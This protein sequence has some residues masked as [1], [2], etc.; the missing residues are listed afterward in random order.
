METVDT[1]KRRS[2]RVWN[3]SDDERVQVDISSNSKLRKL[4]KLEKEKSVDGEEYSRRLREFHENRVLRAK[5]NEW[6]Y[7]A[8]KERMEPIQDGEFSEKEELQP[9]LSSEFCESASGEPKPRKEFRTGKIYRYFENNRKGLLGKQAKA[10]R[11]RVNHSKID[12]KRLVNANIQSP[13]NCVVKSLEFHRGQQV[14][15]GKG[16]SLLSVSGWDKKIKLF[17]VDGTENRL[18]SSLFFENFPIYESRFTNST[19]EMIFLSSGKRIG[20]YDLLEGRINFLPGIAGRRDKRYWNLVVQK[21]DGLSRPYIGLSTSNGNI[22]VLDEQ[23]KQLI[24]S[25]KMNDSV[26]GIA[27]HPTESDQILSTNNVGEIYNW[28]INTGRCIERIVD[29]GSL[30]I[31]GI[32]ASYSSTRSLR[33]GTSQSFVMTGSTTGYVNIYSLRNESSKSEESEFKMPKHVVNNLCTSVTSLA[34]HPGNEI[35]AVASKWSKDSLKLINLETG[36]VYSNWPT[37]R[38]PLKYV[39]SLEFSEYG[40]FLAIG[41]DK[42]DVLLYRLNEYIV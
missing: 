22:L 42:G 32:T 15:N 13:S 3:D 35:A 28:D 19:E 11:F 12:I 23:T 31:S 39:S 2:I 30:C 26:T 25:F 41:N 4:R 7:K 9:N 37:A 20:V 21:S 40:G 38:T 16:A 8:R 10:G 34:I 18:I 1:E 14:V 36:N 27:F 5:G 24:R 17:S 6:I 29:F 33:S